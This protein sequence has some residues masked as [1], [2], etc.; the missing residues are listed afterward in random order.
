MMA[1]R[2][3]ISELPNNIVIWSLIFKKV[4]ETIYTY[5]LLFLRYVAFLVSLVYNLISFV[6]FV[7]DI[8]V[9]RSLA[10]GKWINEIPQ[11]TIFLQ[12]FPLRI[13]GSR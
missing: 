10:K 2:N 1:Y 11:T 13:Q 5:N 12:P 9:T 8:A 7:F 4:S 6:K 3:K